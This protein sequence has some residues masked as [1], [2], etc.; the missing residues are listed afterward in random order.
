[1]VLPWHCKERAFHEL[2]IPLGENLLKSIQMALIEME[3]E[4]MHNDNAQHERLIRLHD[5]V[6]HC[7]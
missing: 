3:Y 7:E 1:M 5:E 4:M 2:L 6:G